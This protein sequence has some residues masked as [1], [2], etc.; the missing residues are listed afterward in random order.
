M[1]NTSLRFARILS[2][3]LLATIPMLL[4]A[5]A[6]VVVSDYDGSNV[7]RFTDSES[8]VAYTGSGDPHEFVPTGSGGLNA[9]TGVTEG[10]DGNVYV[11]SQ[12]TGQIL[13][14]NGTTGA[15]IGVFA[16]LPLDSGY[17]ATPAHLQFYNSSLFVSDYGGGKIESF[18]VTRNGMGQ[19]Q[20]G[21][22]TDVVTGLYVGGGFTFAPNGDMYVSDFGAGEILRIPNGSST[23][24]VFIPPSE[25]LFA[26]NGLLYVNNSLYVDYLYSNQIVKYDADG[27]LT[28]SASVP[29]NDSPPPGNYPS[30]MVLSRDGQSILLA[31][32]GS[33]QTMPLGSVLK[34]DL[35]LDMTGTIATDLP[36]ASSIALAYKRGDFNFDGQVDAADIQA[37]ESALANLS[38]FQSANNLSD[39]QL[40]AI[41]DV[42]GDGVINNADLQS[43]LTVLQSEGGP[44]MASV[45]EPSAFALSSLLLVAIGFHI[46]RR[47][48]PR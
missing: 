34:Y 44:S 22:E 9:A 20:A 14:Y 29:P 32:L 11:S 41:A 6:D 19:L 42:N 38:G 1:K 4:P 27:N 33:S 25:T 10:P 23:P 39:A 17:S 16:T 48:S 5:H 31:V 15:S 37:M 40:D 28:G 7:L 30:D 47:R 36:S 12:N 35:N 43:L 8:N 3:A 21:A 18:A 24:S 46:Y 45:P 2:L 13:E 26:P